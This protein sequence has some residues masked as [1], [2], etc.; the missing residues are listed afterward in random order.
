MAEIQT[1]FSKGGKTTGKLIEVP[2]LR[3]A[4]VQD[5]YLDL[6]EIKTVSLPES[7]LERY[8]LRKGDLLLTEGGDFDK[9][10]RGALWDGQ[11]DDCVHQNHVF[12][13][14]ANE[15]VLDRRFLALLTGSEYGKRYF[16]SC[17]K[18]STNL[19]SI[20]SSQLKA[21]PVPLPPP[22]EQDEIVRLLGLWDK[23]IRLQEELIREKEERKRG[24]MQQLLTGTR[25]LLGFTG[26]W[27]MTRAD[28]VFR[29]KSKKDG[30]DLP[31]LSVTQDS[32]VVVRSESGKQ[33]QFNAENTSTYKVVE[34]GN[35]IISLRSFQGG[36]ELSDLKGKVSPAYHVIE[37]KHTIDHDFYRYYFKS[38]EFIERLDI[39]VIGIRDGKQISYQ[40]FSFMQIPHPSLKEQRAIAKL[41]RQFDHE[42]QNCKLQLENFKT[43]KKGLMQKLLTGR[44]RVKG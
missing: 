22:G 6:S 26:E 41:L 20:N 12:V 8:R 29:R 43:Q 42:L 13:V 30:S 5:G 40:D 33:I 17:S 32:G 25:R 24:L 16:R 3:V 10:G 37:A 31:I 36:L 14:R 38:R 19:A 18:Q 7:K 23:A 4:N 2:Y 34:P 35:F 44:V 15:K 11:I 28:Q 1:G 9:L 21:F 27:P 39:A